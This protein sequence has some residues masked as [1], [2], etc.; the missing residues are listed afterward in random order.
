MKVLGSEGSPTS[1]LMLVVMGVSGSGKTLVGGALATVAGVPFVDGD[2]LHAPEA[3][4][5]MGKGIPLDDSDRAPW[6]DRIGSV[7]ADKATYPKGVVVACSALRRV[8]RDRLR[9]GAGQGL[10]FILLSGDI[11]L[12]RARMSSRR[13]RYMPSSLLESQFATFEPP[14]GESDVFTTPIDG[15]V[16][17]VVETAANVLGLAVRRGR[18]DN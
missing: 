12:I 2:D 9:R 3:V 6:L 18:R 8:Y 14:V 7:L 5:K 11:E 1:R 16:D 13:H 17:Q 10:R 15:T 4:A